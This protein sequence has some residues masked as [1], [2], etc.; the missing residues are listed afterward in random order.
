MKTITKG[1]IGI[2]LIVMVGFFGWGVCKAEEESA[3]GEAIPVAPFGAIDITTPTFEWTSVPGATMYCLLIEDIEAVP[4]YLAWYTDEEAGCAADDAEV[5]AV[6]PSHIV[7]GD[8]WSVLATTAEDYG[9][10]SALMPFAVRNT[11]TNTT[12]ADQGCCDRSS[13]SKAM[14][15]CE[16]TCYTDSQRCFGSCPHGHY[17]IPRR[18]RCRD[19][20]RVTYSQCKEKCKIPLTPLQTCKKKCSDKL[21]WCLN[22]YPGSRCQRVYGKKCNNRCEQDP[23]CKDPTSHVPCSQ[24]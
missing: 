9:Q 10:W 3:L 17:N 6:T 16:M 1:I 21:S 4:V 11:D 19:N 7:H 18:E 13:P 5:C 24:Q 20:C 12:S 2:V 8:A 22:H 23:Q 14:S 15:Q